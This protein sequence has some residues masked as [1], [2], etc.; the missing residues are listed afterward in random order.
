MEAGVD[1]L[2]LIVI[3]G[4]TASGKTG[5]SIDL[6]SKFDGEVISADSRAVYRE[7]DIGT[8]KP[9]I[10]DRRGVPH[11]A[12]DIVNIDENFT[13]ADF[14]YYAKA[15]IADI[16]NRKKIPF[17]VGGTGLYVDAV[18]Y[19][20]EF[21]PAAD[22][23]FRESLNKL[24][25]KELQD[26]CV[27][28]NID[29]PENRLNKRHLIR[30][31]EQKGIN[32]KRS[33]VLGQGTVIVGITTEKVDLQQRIASRAISMFE[34]G[35]V[36]E[37]TYILDKYGEDSLHSKGTVYKD[38]IRLSRGEIDREQAIS[39]LTKSDKKLV[40]KQLTWFKRNSDIQWMTLNEAKKYL[41]YVL[42]N[43]PKS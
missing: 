42:A 5:L 10:L 25:V 32:K 28:N 9:S 43:S 4:P 7:L 29:L 3:V 8:A 35:V 38:A 19:D 13:V 15:K 31:I 41:E 16:R 34:E 40:K 24:S 23:D 26:Y 27:S 20:Y 33:N 36:E 2:P 12:I 22:L 17:L 39:L 18:I 6:A 37:A 11:W 1:S 14:Q 30:A 21:G